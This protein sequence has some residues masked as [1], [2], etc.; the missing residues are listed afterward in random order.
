[1]L[2]FKLQ[3]VLGQNNSLRI[4]GIDLFLLLVFSENRVW[5]DLGRLSFAAPLS[6]LGAAMDVFSLMR[7]DYKK[8]NRGHGACLEKGNKAG[9]GPGSHLEH[10]SK[11]SVG[12]LNI[13]C[14]FCLYI[15]HFPFPLHFVCETL[16]Y[17]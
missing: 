5:V 16:S 11:F 8:D 6:Y 13:P 4:A 2:T 17:K 3:A 12:F 15:F 1:M 10:N 14:V 7:K 9:G